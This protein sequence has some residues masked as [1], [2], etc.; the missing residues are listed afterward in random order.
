[1]QS[2][3]GALIRDNCQEVAEFLAEIIEDA[4]M[5]QAIAK[6][7][8]TEMASRESIFQLLEPSA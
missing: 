5:E 4:A 8:T 2:A 6:G 7:E 1:L 3:I